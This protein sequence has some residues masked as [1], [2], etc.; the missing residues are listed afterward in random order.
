VK[1][2]SH[3]TEWRTEVKVFV[4]LTN[5]EAFSETWETRMAA[6]PAYHKALRWAHQE[7]RALGIRG[8]SRWSRFEVKVRDLGLPAEVA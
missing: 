5:G 3:R 1:S 4:L 6:A 7:M 8:R 2:G